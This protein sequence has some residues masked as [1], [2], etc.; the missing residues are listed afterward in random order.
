MPYHFRDLKK[1]PNS[2]SFPQFVFVHPVFLQLSA[3]GI[4]ESRVERL[5][6]RELEGHDELVQD[7]RGG[8]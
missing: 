4:H 2:K 7:S 8:L 6:E 3:S 5:E 1:D